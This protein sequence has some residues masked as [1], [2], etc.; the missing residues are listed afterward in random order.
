MFDT[1]NYVGF[2]SDIIPRTLGNANYLEIFIM[3]M[4]FQ[5]G[6]CTY[7]DACADD[8]KAI[9]KPLA[10]YTVDERNVFRSSDENIK[11]ILKEAIDLHVDM[12]KLV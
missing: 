12:L 8:Y 3:F 7:I 2:Y 9:M 10:D 4:L 1:H 5:V 11:S 6:F